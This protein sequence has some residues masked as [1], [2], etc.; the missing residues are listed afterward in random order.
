MSTST[1]SYSAEAGQVLK[2]IELIKLGARMQVLESEF[3]TLSRDRLGRLYRETRGIS[4]PKGM[5]PFSADWYLTWGPN[6]HASLFGSIY[7]SLLANSSGR[8]AS[9]DLLAKT[10]TLYQEH[11]ASTGKEVQMD[12]T[13]AWTL[14]RFLEGGILRMAP[15]TRCGG[16][17]VA[18]KQDLVHDLV[19]GL[20]Q[21]PSRA[22]KT[23][24]ARKAAQG[25]KDVSEVKAPVAALSIT[26]RS[27]A[28]KAPVV[29]AT[30][31][32]AA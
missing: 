24:A 15:C 31:G 22:G 32:E 9:I 21:P 27:K 10:Y 28:V 13:R 29:I 1:K 12:L 18:H 14:L 25:L 20:C 19:C 3:P 7:N 26:T 17:F 2:A 5:L 6:I 11:I 8:L 4:P 16:Q 30:G 23:N